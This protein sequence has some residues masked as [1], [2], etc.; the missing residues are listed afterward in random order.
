MIKLRLLFSLSSSD[1]KL[2]GGVDF[3]VFCVLFSTFNQIIKL[4]DTILLLLLLI[5]Q[6]SSAFFVLIHFSVT[7]HFAATQSNATCWCCDLRC[8]VLLIYAELSALY[9]RGQPRG[10]RNFVYVIFLN[11][12]YLRHKHQKV[13]TANYK[14]LT[15]T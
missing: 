5:R 12:I 6:H 2:D 14:C 3:I 11:V 13:E 7:C 8:Q 10:H 15:L 4:H 9:H 1:S